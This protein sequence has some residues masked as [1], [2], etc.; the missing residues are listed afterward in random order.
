MSNHFSKLTSSH[1]RFWFFCSLRN[2][3]LLR[4]QPAAAAPGKIYR[5]A[6]AVG[7][8]VRR[9]TLSFRDTRLEQGS[10]PA[11][12]DARSPGISP[13]SLQLRL[14]PAIPSA[15][16]VWPLCW[17][18]ATSDQAIGFPPKRPVLHSLLFSVEPQSVESR[19]PPR[20]SS[21]LLR[22]QGST[23]SP[24]PTQT[25]SDI[26]DFRASEADNPIPSCPWP[27]FFS[28][29]PALTTPPLLSRKGSNILVQLPVSGRLPRQPPLAPQSHLQ[30]KGLSWL[31]TCCRLLP[32]VS[33]GIGRLHPTDWVRGRRLFYL[34][35]SWYE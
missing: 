11:C 32:A 25:W 1:K 10:P 23:F 26:L 27:W 30:T 19:L 33:P 20:P 8:A 22:V 18:E 3:H 4:L 12:L 15:G 13:V 28:G 29:D 31:L 35:H 24:I 9:S 16:S 6:A 7:A 17:D 2:R 34:L 14:C 5:S 21:L